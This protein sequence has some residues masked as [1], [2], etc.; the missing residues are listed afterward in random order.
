[1]KVQIND[2]P[3]RGVLYIPNQTGFES[4]MLN[5]SIFLPLAVEYN[6]RIHHYPGSGRFYFIAELIM[7]FGDNGV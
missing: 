5:D 1:L 6:V 4:N 3:Q 2:N 7:S